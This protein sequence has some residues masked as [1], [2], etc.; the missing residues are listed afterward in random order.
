MEKIRVKTFQYHWIDDVVLTLTAGLFITAFALLAAANDWARAV[1][2]FGTAL[3]IK[4][5][6]A[7]VNG[8]EEYMAEK[9]GASPWPSLAA[10]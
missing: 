8:Q 7:I 2:A 4:C 10:G 5:T 3:L 9:R 6:A 1:S